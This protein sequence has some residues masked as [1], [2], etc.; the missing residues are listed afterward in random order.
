MRA[1]Y[2]LHLSLPCAGWSPGLGRYRALADL[3][4][5]PQLGG[6]TLLCLIDGL[7]AGYYWDSHPHPWQ[8]APFGNGTNSDWPSSNKLLG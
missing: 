3:M 4:G 8:S 5:H 7:F 6:N 1:Y 2:N